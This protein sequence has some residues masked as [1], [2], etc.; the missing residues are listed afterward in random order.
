LPKRR[1]RNEDPV[2]KR[3]KAAKAEK[4]RAINKAKAEDK[5]KKAT[6]AEAAK[7]MLVEME[8]D[9]SFAQMQVDQQRIRRQS[10]LRA[11]IDGGN[12]DSS[13]CEFASLGDEEPSDTSE[14]ESDTLLDDETEQ[15]RKTKVSVGLHEAQVQILTVSTSRKM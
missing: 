3:A 6:E 14:G 15:L 12:H 2:G 9:E 8:I 11:M 1:G 7:E 5:K 13:E 10:D 4:T